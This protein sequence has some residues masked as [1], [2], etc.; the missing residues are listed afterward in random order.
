M[1]WFAMEYKERG[2]KNI[3]IEEQLWLYLKENK[4]PTETFSEV[5]WGFISL[6]EDEPKKSVGE[7]GFVDNMINEKEVL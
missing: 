2:L 4:N 5:I 3:A 1:S 7:I 6:S